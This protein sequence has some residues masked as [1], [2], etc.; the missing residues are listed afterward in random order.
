[1]K[2]KKADGMSLNIIVLAVIALA[3]LVVILAV[4][5]NKMRQG[6]NAQDKAGNDVQSSV[7]LTCV[8]PGQNCPN[9]GTGTPVNSN[10]YINCPAGN[11]CCS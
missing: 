9:G 3:V 11:Y 7:C 4:F 2:S 6:S 10:M 8:P 5:G 1:M